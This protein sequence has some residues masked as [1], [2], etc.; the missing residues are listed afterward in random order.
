MPS[1]QAQSPCV[2]MNRTPGCS[3]QAAILS[4]SS[5]LP[6]GCPPTGRGTVSAAATASS[7]AERALAEGA[8]VAAASRP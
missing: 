5:T 2:S 6:A 4:A 1:G 8:A 7:A 3:S